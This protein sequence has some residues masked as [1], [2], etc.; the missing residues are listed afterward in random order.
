MSNRSSI[1]APQT[2]HAKSSAQ[3]HTAQVLILLGL[4]P[5]DTGPYDHYRQFDILNGHSSEKKF[6]KWFQSQKVIF[7]FLV[8]KALIQKVIARKILT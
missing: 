3:G 6:S 8:P 4:H 7:L 5:M 2:G 1:V